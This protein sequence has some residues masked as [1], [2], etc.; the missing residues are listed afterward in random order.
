[1]Q[2]IFDQ[3]MT[4]QYCRGGRKFVCAYLIISLYNR[5]TNFKSHFE[6]HLRYF[7]HFTQSHL[8]PPTTVTQ[9]THFPFLLFFFFLPPAAPAPPV[10]S[11]L[12]PSF[13]S[14]PSVSSSSPPGVVGSDSFVGVEVAVS[15]LDSSF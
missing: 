5:S 4:Q 11:G 15:C 6:Q 10:S 7:S 14:P 12:P 9:R 2:Q 1:M 3:D 8:A 13:A